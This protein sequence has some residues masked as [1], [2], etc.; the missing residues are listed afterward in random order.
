VREEVVAA[1]QEFSNRI[2]PARRFRV[3]PGVML[4]QAAAAISVTVVSTAAP[5]IVAD[6]GG[7]DRYAW[8]FAA[9]TLTA[10]IAGV[11]VGKLSDLAGRRPFYVGAAV[12][13]APARC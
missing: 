13:F 8:I 1:H 4:T 6:L 2:D 5:R 7:A 12:L 11:I 9:Y 3:L 10:G